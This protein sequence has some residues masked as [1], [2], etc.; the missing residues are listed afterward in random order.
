[1]LVLILCMQKWKIPFFTLTAFS[2]LYSLSVPY[3]RFII[4]ASAYCHITVFLSSRFLLSLFSAQKKRQGQKKISSSVL[5]LFTFI[6]IFSSSYY[7][8][9]LFPNQRFIRLQRICVPRRH[10][11]ETNR[12]PRQ[13]PRYKLCGLALLCGVRNDFLE[14]LPAVIH[15]G[16]EKVQ[17]IAF[18]YN[19]RP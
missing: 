11:R 13:I 6:I 12:E 17:L 8:L 14:A 5:C 16:P 9:A 4:W 19:V 7:G 10:D 3:V 2:T 18:H 15:K 1:M